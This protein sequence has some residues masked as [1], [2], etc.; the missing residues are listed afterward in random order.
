MDNVELIK[1]DEKAIVYGGF[2][3]AIIQHELKM[4]SDF[5]VENN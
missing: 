4:A 5:I 3:Y 1:H 2:S